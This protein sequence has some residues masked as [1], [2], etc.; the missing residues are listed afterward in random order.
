MHLHPLLSHQPEY[1]VSTTALYTLFY[2]KNTL[3]DTQISFPPNQLIATCMGL[4]GSPCR[5]SL[6]PSR[7]HPQRLLLREGTVSCVVGKGG[8]RYVRRSIR[9]GFGQWGRS[10]LLEG[11]W[12]AGQFRWL[13]LLVPVRVLLVC[14]RIQAYHSGSG[15]AHVVG[16]RAHTNTDKPICKVW[17]THICLLIVLQTHT[18]TPPPPLSLSLS[19][20]LLSLSLSHT[21]A[22]A[23]TRSHTCTCMHRHKRCPPSP[24]FRHTS[25]CT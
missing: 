15:C 17:H 16:I 10:F 5:M 11:I 9:R 19:P 13:I 20:S 23:H 7:Q 24:P 6:G 1:Y 8:M 12:W 3:T 22:R 18:R 2:G 25:L 4:S 21:H 14:V